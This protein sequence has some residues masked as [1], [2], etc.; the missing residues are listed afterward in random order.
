MTSDN[1]KRWGQFLPLAEWWYNTNYHISAQQTPFEI[2][3]GYP[4]P[5]YLPYIPGDSRNATVDS[6]LMGREE[7]IRILKFHL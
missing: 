7:V 1:P 2:L 4:P 3:Y 5:L 6:M